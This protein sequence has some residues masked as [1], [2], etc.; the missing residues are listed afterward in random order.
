MSGSPWVYLSSS[1]PS[2]RIKK[3]KVFPVS[4]L[5]WLTMPSRVIQTS[6]YR[7]PCKEVT[8]CKKIQF[9]WALI[10]MLR[11]PTFA[12]KTVWKKMILRFF[13]CKT[14]K[15]EWYMMLSM[16]EWAHFFCMTIIFYNIKRW[17]VG[18]TSESLGWAH[19][20]SKLEGTGKNEMGGELDPY[21]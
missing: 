5:S 7:R 18:M 1:L 2:F 19:K 4:K 15:C 3:K 17:M 16:S 6:Y 8:T 21:L 11:I 10:A 9:D 20:G 14:V 13:S 12:R